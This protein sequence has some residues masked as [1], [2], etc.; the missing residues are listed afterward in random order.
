MPT[1]APIKDF[2]A[3]CMSNFLV[4]HHKAPIEVKLVIARIRWSSYKHSRKTNQCPTPIVYS[5][6]HMPVNKKI[7]FEVLNNKLVTSSVSFKLFIK[8]QEL[9]FL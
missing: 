9:G 6:F 2:T 4:N 5:I 3:G 1:V 7:S 8:L